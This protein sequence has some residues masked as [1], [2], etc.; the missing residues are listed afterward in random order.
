MA[1]ILLQHGNRGSHVFGKRELVYTVLQAERSVG[2]PQG[3]QGADLSVRIPLNLGGL[4]QGGER[5]FEGTDFAAILVAEYQAFR[6][7][8]GFGIFLGR[9]LLDPQIMNPLQVLFDVRRG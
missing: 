9:Q 5:L 3:V 1:V 8:L 2:V 4:Q 7:E 6:I